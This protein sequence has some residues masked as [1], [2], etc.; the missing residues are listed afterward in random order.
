[1]T[2]LADTLLDRVSEII[3]RYSMLSAGDRVGVAV[4]G[5]ADSVALLHIIHRLTAKLQV[6][7]VVLH[8][9]HHLRGQ[10]S[11]EDEAFVRSLAD[12]LGLQVFLEHAPVETGNVE[13]QA[14]N[15]RRE[16]FLR[17]MHTA[18]VV[19]RVAL[20]HT[21]SD[22]AETV[23]FR[24][25]RGSGLAG[26]AGMRIS[27]AEGFIR[28]LL[29]SSREEVRTWATDQ[30]IAWR[31]DS[32][33]ADVKFARNRLRNEVM[34]ELA[35]HFNPNLELVLAGTAE[36]AAAEESYWSEAIAPLYAQITK[37]THLGV[38]LATRALGSFHIAVQRRVIRRALLEVR[39]DLRGIDRRHIDAIL[40]ICGS[41]EGHDRV[42]VPGIDALR[43]FDQ[44]LLACPGTLSK[45]TRG[46]VRDLA[47]GQECELP[48]RTGF[49]CIDEVNSESQFCANFKEDQELLEVV[50]LDGR[51]IAVAGRPG[52]LAVRNWEPGDQLHRAG[53]QGAEKI[54]SL[55]QEYR[56]PLW[57]RR[58]WPVLVHRNEIIWARRF[59]CAQNFK[60]SEESHRVLRVTFRAAE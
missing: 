55:F 16:C 52:F 42:L 36:V 37:R 26:L 14:R 43:S 22:Q 7:P 51:Q 50:D 34:P 39:G 18:G 35:R 4:S 40:V 3:P 20:G 48:F 57:Q 10:E 56:V 6:H 59:G 44:L 53:H 25:L 13:E 27:T 15:S 11:N 28:P 41:E 30:G 9:N 17:A 54:K 29:T 5:G 32:S 45:E 21:R 33:N 1:M 60:R 31:E 24:L 2:I 38:I 23:L 19:D 12:S 8:V 46:Y 58:H 47:F 49:I